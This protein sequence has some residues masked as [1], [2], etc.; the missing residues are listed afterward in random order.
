MLVAQSQGQAPQR[1]VVLFLMSVVAMGKRSETKNWFRNTQGN[2]LLYHL[3]NQFISLILLLKKYAKNSHTK[4]PHPFDTGEHGCRIQYTFQCVLFETA[5]RHYRI[6][7]IIRRKAEVESGRMCTIMGELIANLRRAMNGA[8][9]TAHIYV[10]KY[11]LPHGIA[12]LNA[13]VLVRDASLARLTRNLLLYLDHRL[14]SLYKSSVFRPPWKTE[15]Y[16]YCFIL[17]IK[18][19]RNR[20]YFYIRGSV[21]I[22]FNLNCSHLYEHLRSVTS[23]G[24]RLQT[25]LSDASGS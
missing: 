16:M 21:K 3:F 1:S 4:S 18:L 12:C 14:L 23:L 9:R 11:L 7:Y 17:C 15:I 6:C 24:T 8:S 2:T 25:P 13:V 10:C 5:P 22:I 20:M 19:V